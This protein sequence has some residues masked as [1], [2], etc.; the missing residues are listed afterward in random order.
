M[1]R[2]IPQSRA[3]NPGLIHLNNTPPICLNVPQHLVCQ[4]R[5]LAA[6]F[7]IYSLK[8]A[9]LASHLIMRFKPLGPALIYL[10]NTL[11]TRFQ[12]SPHFIR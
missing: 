5:A 12:V 2:S 9:P 7:F 1:H 11:P 10:N 6:R 8:L 3:L 4:N